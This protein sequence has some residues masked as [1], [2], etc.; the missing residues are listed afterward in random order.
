[1]FGEIKIPALDVKLLFGLRPLRPN[2][3]KTE[4]EDSSSKWL[5]F[6]VRQKQHFYSI[7]KPKLRLSSGSKAEALVW[8]KSKTHFISI[9]HFAK[10][11]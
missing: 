3:C 9:G 10:R 6:P 4:L 2:C 7:K 8:L 1:M 11:S 5:F